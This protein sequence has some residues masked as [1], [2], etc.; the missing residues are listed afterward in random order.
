MWTPRFQPNRFA[1]CVSPSL[2]LLAP[3]ISDKQTGGHMRQRPGASAKCPAHPSRRLNLSRPHTLSDSAHFFIS[4]SPSKRGLSLCSGYIRVGFSSLPF[5]PLFSFPLLHLNPHLNP[6]QNLFWKC[7]KSPPHP[8][9]S[10]LK[11]TTT[12][13]KWNLFARRETFGSRYSSPYHLLSPLITHPF[14]VIEVQNGPKW[15]VWPSRNRGSSEEVDENHNKETA[16]QNGYGALRRSVIRQ[17]KRK[18]DQD[19]KHQ[20]PKPFS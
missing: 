12:M 10:L 6:F 5:S 20:N 15:F 18:Q 14:Q 11:P 16:G 13:L 3:V 19:G 8:L 2:S 17:S 1:V 4:L 7:L 9:P